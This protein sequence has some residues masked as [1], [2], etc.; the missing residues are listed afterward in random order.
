MSSS[1]GFFCCWVDYVLHLNGYSKVMFFL[2]ATWCLFSWSCVTASGEWTFS[3]RVV[4]RAK[5]FCAFFS[6]FFLFRHQLIL[7]G[8]CS[9]AGPFVCE[10][11]QREEAAGKSGGSDVPQHPSRAKASSGSRGRTRRLCCTV[12]HATCWETIAFA[13]RVSVGQHTNVL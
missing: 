7:L 4:T 5:Y 1:S 3:C 2:R 6:V 9:C 13:F 11:C 10:I 8:R 12:P